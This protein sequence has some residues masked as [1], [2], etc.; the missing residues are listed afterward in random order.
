M[1]LFSHLV[2]DATPL[3][4]RNLHPNDPSHPLLGAPMPSLAFD[5]LLRLLCLGHC[6]LDGRCLEIDHAVMEMEMQLMLRKMVLA[7]VGQSIHEEEEE[8]EDVDSAFHQ[9]R[10]LAAIQAFLIGAHVLH[11]RFPYL[12][13]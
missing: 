1:V 4:E 13:A 11:R 6:R 12:T 2:V 5:P 8:D 7:A 3:V 10:V 9:S